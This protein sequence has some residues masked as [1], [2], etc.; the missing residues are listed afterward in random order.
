LKSLQD[1]SDQNLDQAI[2]AAQ[3]KGAKVSRDDWVFPNWDPT[4]DYTKHD[5]SG[6]H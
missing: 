3:A 5:Y 4:K 1:R 2:K 6:V